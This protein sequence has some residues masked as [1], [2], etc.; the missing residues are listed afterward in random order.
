MALG[1]IMAVTAPQGLRVGLILTTFG[2]GFRHGIDWDHIAAIT[3]I[4][5]SQDN[6]RQS[7]L[8]ATLYALGHAVVVF[9][10]GIAAIVLSRRLPASVD[11]VMEQFVGAT[12]LLLGVYV[13][14]S[15][16]RRGSDFRMR[17]RWMLLIGAMRHGVR[18]VRARRDRPVVV[19]HEHEHLAVEAH[20]DDHRPVHVGVLVAAGTPD[21]A[22]PVMHRHSHR[23]IGTAPDDPFMEYGRATALGVGMIHGI[24]AETPTQIL[25]F[26]AVAG[27]GGKATGVALLL[28]FLVGLLTS[29]SIIALASTMGF[30]G[31]SRNV[32]LYVAV[33]IVTASFS[34]VIGTLFLLGRATVLPAIFGG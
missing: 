34:L 19:E 5:S 25:I 32:R 12:L 29:N 24:G 4:T 6:R 17:S 14:A 26:L 13:F 22:G 27:A 7:M 31:A 16:A 20:V 1:H 23:H 18:W 11:R 9:T 30:A 2:F 15:L 33:S 8:L 3:D 10:L 28:C 21:G